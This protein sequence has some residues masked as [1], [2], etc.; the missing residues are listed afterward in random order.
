ML[1]E[2]GDRPEARIPGTLDVYE[3]LCVPVLAVDTGFKIIYINEKA[4]E[5][6]G[7]SKDAIKGKRLFDTSPYA[8]PW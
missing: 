2:N 5:M 1:V 7:H 4:C 6:T 8:A 3:L